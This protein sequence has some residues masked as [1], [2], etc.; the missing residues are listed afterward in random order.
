M[1]ER[2]G[3]KTYRD[4]Q[5]KVKRQATAGRKYLQ[6]RYIKNFDRAKRKT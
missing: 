4:W 6:C 2:V 3:A 5:D 1:G